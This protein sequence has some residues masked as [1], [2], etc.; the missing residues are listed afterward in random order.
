M[1][2]LT[3]LAAPCYECA[4]LEARIAEKPNKDADQTTQRFFEA[5]SVASLS[6]EMGLAILAGWWVGQ[7]LDTRFDTEPWLMILFLLLGVAAAF[8]AIFRTAKQAQK[9][10]ATSDTPD[11]SE[12]E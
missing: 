3:T 2:P 8:K 11:D 1:S 6:L 5:A 10:L 4:A 12:P 9:Y 7:Y